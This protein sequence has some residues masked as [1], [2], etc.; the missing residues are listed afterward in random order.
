MKQALIDPIDLIDGYPSVV[1]V[2]DTPF[3]TVPEYYWVECPDDTVSGMYYNNGTFVLPPPPAPVPPV[4]PT[5]AENKATAV[6]KLNNS[7]WTQ[8]PSVSDPALSNPYLLNKN[9][10]DIWRNSIRQYALNPVEGLI[11]WPTKPTE[12]WSN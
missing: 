12:Q 6:Q 9:E 7:D 8:I 3:E 1:S 10:F 5:A 11:D 4:P 2:N